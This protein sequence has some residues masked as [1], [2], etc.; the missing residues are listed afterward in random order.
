VIIERCHRCVGN[1]SC[2]NQVVATCLPVPFFGDIA[3]P[4][5][6]VV[7]VGLNPALNE[8]YTNGTAKALSQRLALLQDFNVG[9]RTD[10]SDEDVLKAKTRRDGY[11]TNHERAWHSYF[12]KMESVLTRVSPAWTYA[13]GSAVHIDLVACATEKRFGDLSPETKSSLI[14][15]CREHFV[16]TLSTLPNST[17]ILCDGPRATRELQTEG[18]Q[19]MGLHAAMQPAQLI[20]VRKPGSGDTGWI[21][22]L[23]FQG[24]KFP[25]RGWSSQV[26]QLTAVWRIDL[27]SWIHGTILPPSSWPPMQARK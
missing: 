2:E 25:L 19:N 21:G 7:T 15:N 16:S 18:M 3:K 4:N 24:K 10:L 12:E 23:S 9:T 14:G 20:N 22:E 13:F 27:A 8:F 6:K 5:L 1:P 11:F 26:S 17:M